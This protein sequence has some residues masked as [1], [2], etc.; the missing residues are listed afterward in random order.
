[1]DKDYHKEIMRAIG[2]LEGTVKTGF[3]GT[4][5]RQDTA[6][7]RTDKVEIRLS[8]VEEENTAQET[9]L[10]WLKKNYWVIV[11]ASIGTFFTVVGGIMLFLLMN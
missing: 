8:S 7:N 9:D 11:T 5:K 3:D 10:K 2:N 6:N 1:M 4:H